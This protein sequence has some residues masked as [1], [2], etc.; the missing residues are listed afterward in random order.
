VLFV[1]GKSEVIAKD[2]DSLSDGSTVVCG[3]ADGNGDPFIAW[4]SPDGDNFRFVHTSP[5]HPQRLS[6]GPNGT[7]GFESIDGNG[8][9]GIGRLIDT[10]PGRRAR[11]G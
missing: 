8:Y 2:F 10:Q 11:H 7:V 9:P 6:A 1:P 4:I 3:H 5:Y